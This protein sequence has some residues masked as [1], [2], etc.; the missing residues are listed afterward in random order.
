VDSAQINVRVKD[1]PNPMVMPNAFTPNGDGRNDYF[2]PVTF[3]NIGTVKTFRIYDRW[4]QLVHD[5]TGPWDGKFKGEKQPP[6]T[7]IYY[8]DIQIPNQGDMHVEGAV[9]LLR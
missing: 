7:Y 1:S 2:Y 5:V 8:L 3:N 4:G 6:G 9:T